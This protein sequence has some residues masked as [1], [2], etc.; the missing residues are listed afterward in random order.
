MSDTNDIHDDPRLTAFALG[1]LDGAERADVE[2]L[3]AKDE[4][5]RR[6]VEEIRATAAVV[7]EEL[8]LEPATALTELQR[9]R[10][11]A[12]ATS[13][14]RR[15]HIPRVYRI[16]PVTSIAAASLVVGA[17]GGAMSALEWRA[18]HEVETARGHGARF[19]EDLAGAPEVEF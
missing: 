7:A 16:G 4:A 2:A 10:I 17:V 6:A 8:K 3:V 13:V 9:A 19:D 1:E 11:A 18:S 14:R 5:A 12:T 15:F